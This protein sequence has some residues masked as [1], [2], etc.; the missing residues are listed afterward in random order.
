MSVLRPERKDRGRGRDEQGV[1]VRQPQKKQ[2]TEKTEKK[3][4]Q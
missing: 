4:K 1:R 3:K 2:K